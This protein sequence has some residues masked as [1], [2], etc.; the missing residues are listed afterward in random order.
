[1]SCYLCIKISV[2][3]LVVVLGGN[4]IPK[5]GGVVLCCLGLGGF[6]RFYGRRKKSISCGFEEKRSAKLGFRF[7]CNLLKI[8]H[9]SVIVL[10]GFIERADLENCSV[11]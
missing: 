1:M 7:I 8:P 5:S 3:V 10:R 2:V 11:S 4:G 6:V 9:D